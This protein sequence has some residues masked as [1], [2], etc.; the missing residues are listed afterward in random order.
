MFA[1][2]YICDIPAYDYLALTAL[3][4]HIEAVSAAVINSPWRLF[5]A[6]P[7]ACIEERFSTFA[8]AY[9]NMPA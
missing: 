8:F 2:G 3:H 7:A 6:S 5:G 1:T 9:E 4:L